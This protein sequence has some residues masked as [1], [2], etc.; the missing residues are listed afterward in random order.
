MDDPK[1]LVARGYDLVADAYWERF[2][3]SE[4][5]ERWLKLLI[6]RLPERARVLDLGCGAGV[7]VARELAA[8]NFEVIGVDGSPR[9]IELAIG[10]VPAARFILA[11]MSSVAFASSSF[12]AVSAFYSITH[13]PRDEHAALLGRIA[14]W[15]KPEG[16]FVGALGAQSLHDWRGEW[17]G[18]EMYF[19][20]YDAKT[21][22]GLIREAGL[23]IEKV[24]IVPQ[25]NEDAKFMWVIARRPPL[26]QEAAKVLIFVVA[27]EA[28]Q[29]SRRCV[30][31]PWIAS[32]RSQ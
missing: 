14:D 26:G 22:E 21:N 17:L 29:S 9:Q 28:K 32:L 7:P 10:N 31:H 13:V 15:L 16:I 11:D 12:D 20:H 8:H 1:S 27:S 2:G 30:R 19:S 25:D 23:A 6:A 18:A 5:R 3:A 4:V 24:E